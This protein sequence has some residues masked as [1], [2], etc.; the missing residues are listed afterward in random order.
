MWHTTTAQNTQPEETI[1]GRHLERIESL[2]LDLLENLLVPLQLFIGRKPVK[3]GISFLVFI[4]DLE[5]ILPPWKVWMIIYELTT[6]GILIS[7]TLPAAM[8]RGQSSQSM[9]PSTSQSAH[10]LERIERTF[11]EYSFHFP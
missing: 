10:P 2:G 4:P 8:E 3:I 5:G 7:S 1:P 9:S 11:S 6:I